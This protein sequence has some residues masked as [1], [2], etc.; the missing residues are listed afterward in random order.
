MVAS[1]SD[2]DERCYGGELISVVLL[3][4]R[5]SSPLWMKFKR[6]ERTHRR[7]NNRV[8]VMCSSYVIDPYKTLRIQP[9][10]SE[11]EVKKG[12]RQLA[13]QV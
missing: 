11:S 3:V 9:S 12:L 2:G 13:L 8:K 4:I 10:A 6:R 1:D 7:V 5:L